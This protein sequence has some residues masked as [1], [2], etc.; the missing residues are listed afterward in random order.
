[1]D[2]FAQAVTGWHDFYVLIGTAAATLVGLLFVALTL[3]ADRFRKVQYA[4]TCLLAYCSFYTFL[5]SFINP[6]VLLIPNQSPVGSGL[7]L[8]LIG[9]LGVNNTLRNI[10]AVRQGER[11]ASFRHVMRRFAS[12][13]VSL[14]GL[15][16][17][18]LWIMTG[19]VAAFYW[20]TG[21]IILLVVSATENAWDML[22]EMY[23]EPA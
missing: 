6:G 9:L 23:E 12:V 14:A 15:I 22:M 1:M 13:L 7:P 4:D 19:S 8:L 11:N 17:L 21:A 3:N 18:S 2:P 5:T 20:L 10:R 16:V